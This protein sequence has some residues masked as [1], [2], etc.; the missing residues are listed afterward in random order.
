M[1]PLHADIP[2]LAVQQELTD[3]NSVR[4]QDVV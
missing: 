4:T 2:V 3:N 1:D